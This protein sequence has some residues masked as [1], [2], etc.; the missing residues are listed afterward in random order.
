MCK[1][2]GSARAPDLPVTTLLLLLLLPGV[3][4]VAAAAELERVL[5]HVGAPRQLVAEEHGDD[6]SWS[7]DL[8]EQ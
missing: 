5:A 3:V 4:V 6:D 1:L 8:G 7:K 2:P